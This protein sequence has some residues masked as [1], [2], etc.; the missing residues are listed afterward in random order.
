MEGGREFRKE[1]IVSFNRVSTR[2][3][4]QFIPEPEPSHLPPLRRW[5]WEQI[6]TLAGPPEIRVTLS[7]E[8]HLLLLLLLLSAA[9][10]IYLLSLEEFKN[11]HF[12]ISDASLC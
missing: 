4:S 2:I 10:Y 3:Y 5:E 9:F 12:C 7:R 11:A 8:E 6:R 1:K